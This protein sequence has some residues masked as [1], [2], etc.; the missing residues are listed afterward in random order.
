MSY[1]KMQAKIY[2]VWK[3]EASLKEKNTKKLLYVK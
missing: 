3:S 2:N 1:R